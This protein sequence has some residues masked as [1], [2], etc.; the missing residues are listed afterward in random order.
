M[1]NSEHEVILKALQTDD[2][3]VYSDKAISF[4]LNQIFVE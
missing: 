3:Y 4:Q 1:Q 2:M